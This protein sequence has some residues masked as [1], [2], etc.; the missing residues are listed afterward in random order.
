MDVVIDLARVEWRDRRGRRVNLAFGDGTIVATPWLP[1]LRPGAVITRGFRRTLRDLVVW[2]SG[3]SNYYRSK[4]LNQF[5][6]ATSFS[7][8]GTLYLALWT[9]TLSASST[10]STSGE[11]SYT[12]YARVAVTAN[13]TNFSTSAGGSA[14]TN[15]TAD[16]WPPNAGSLQTATDLMVADASTAGD[17]LYWGA[18]A[19]PA[20]IN[21]GNTPQLDVSAL[22]SS[23][24]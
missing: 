4:L 20:A 23:E 15:N 19:S 14:V 7:F 16:T 21:P 12:G 22:S 6:S 8:P 18:L 24:A 10:G 9:S 13:G 1:S 5:W 17:S 11:C 2:A 3:K